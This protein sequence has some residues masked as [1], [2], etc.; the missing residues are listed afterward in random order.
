MC[1]QDWPVEA[2]CALGYLRL[3]GRGAGDR[4]RGRG[5][6][7]PAAASRPTSGSANRPRA[8]GSSTG[9]TTRR[10]TRC[11]ASCWPRSSGPSRSGPRRV[12][13]GDPRGRGRPVR[14]RAE[15]SR[16]SL[17]L[18]SPTSNRTSCHEGEAHD[19]PSLPEVEGEPPAGP[20]L[21]A[22]TTGRA[23][24]TSTRPRAS[25]PVAEWATSAARPRCRPRPR[26]PCRVRRRRSPSWPSGRRTDR[27]LWHPDDLTLETIADRR[28]STGAGVLRVRIGPVGPMG[29]MGPVSPTRLPRAR[30]Q[31]TIRPSGWL[32][33]RGPRPHPAA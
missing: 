29:P 9:S 17:R 31:G 5:V 20:V 16:D 30:C 33:R 8:G 15:W 22:A 14:R 28:R 25:T 1:V 12:T 3:A 13:P 7:R 11:G 32:R 6:L 27:S 26:P 18:T 10:A 24:A 4:R 23:C 19:L 2:A 21:V